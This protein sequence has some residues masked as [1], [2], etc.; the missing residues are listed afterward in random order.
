MWVIGKTWRYKNSKVYGGKK[1]N[2]YANSNNIISW[3]PRATMT[4]VPEIQS[5]L[6]LVNQSG[7]KQR[8]KRYQLQLRSQ[9]RSLHQHFNSENHRH[10]FDRNPPVCLLTAGWA[11]GLR[12][13][14][15]H[16]LDSL[17]MK[18]NQKMRSRSVC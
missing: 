18:Q 13:L 4:Y 17:T 5:P 2:Q 11:T 6:L 15:G 8:N 1:F 16:K 3:N 10:P 7:R 14:R 9:W 12:H